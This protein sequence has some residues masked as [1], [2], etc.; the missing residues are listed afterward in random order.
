MYIKNKKI[1]K[2]KNKKIKSR[3]ITLPTKFCISESFVSSGSCVRVVNRFTCWAIKKFE[4][5]RIDAFKLWCWRR[6]LRVLWT[7]CKEIKPVNPKGN[8][9]WI[10]TEK[11]DT[12]AKA[13]IYLTWCEEPT[14]WKRPW[15]WE[16]LMARG[17]VGDRGRDI[18]MASLTQWTWVWASSRR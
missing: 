9:P 10:F 12:E 5:W 11:T 8:Q 17:E 1:A 14:H 6:H 13:P 7:V 4:G 2:I 16:R 18:W 15:C 3:D